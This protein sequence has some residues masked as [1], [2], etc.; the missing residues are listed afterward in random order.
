MDVIGVIISV[1]FVS[2]VALCIYLLVI[3][4]SENK[5]KK[6]SKTEKIDDTL[7]NLYSSYL[8]LN[9][10]SLEAYKALMIAALEASKKE[11]NK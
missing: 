1:L 8:S 3:F 11:L 6:Q 2:A 10:D 5:T 7:Y 4:W 9:N